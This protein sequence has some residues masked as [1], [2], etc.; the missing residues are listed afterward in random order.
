MIAIQRA[1][2]ALSKVPGHEGPAI[3]TWLNYSRI[4]GLGNGDYGVSGFF[5]LC[6]RILPFVYW[7]YGP[8]FHGGAPWG[9]DPRVIISTEQPDP[10]DM[11]Q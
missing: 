6:R 9:S 5:R 8:E 10:W 4:P 11:A 2:H 1:P 3:A 7:K